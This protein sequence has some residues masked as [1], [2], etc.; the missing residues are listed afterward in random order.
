MFAGNRFATL[1]NQWFF[2][3]ACTLIGA[4][5]VWL[6]ICANLIGFT[7]GLDG[8]QLVI[9]SISKTTSW[10]DV[11]AFVVCHYAAVNLM[12]Y[13]RFGKQEWATKY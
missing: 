11:G 1:Q 3:P 13:V 8:L 2:R 7:F 12:M 9:A 6:M 4:V 10:F 5:N